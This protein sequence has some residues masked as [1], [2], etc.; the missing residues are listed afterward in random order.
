MGL[1]FIYGKSGCGKSNFCYNQIKNEIDKEEKIYMITPEQFSFTAEKTL[2]EVLEKKSVI[3]VE[4]I[5]FKRMAQRI[6]SEVYGAA[7]T[8]LSDSGKSMLLYD[9]LIKTRTN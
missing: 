5:T 4:V 7:N 2:L 8:V 3:K 9:V 6:F 1:R